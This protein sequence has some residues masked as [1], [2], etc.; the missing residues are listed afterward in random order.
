MKT[1]GVTGGS[2]FVGQHLCRLLVREGYEVIIFSR[3][4]SGVKPGGACRYAGWNP[5]AGTID[6]HALK[7]LDAVVN[8]AGA[9]I[10]E[11]RWTKKRKQELVSSR[12][13]S[14][15][16]LVGQLRLH[17][18]A[19]RV[20]LSASAAGYYGPDQRSMISFS[21]DASAYTDF[22]AGLC[23]EWEA[24]ANEATDFAR[25]VICRL[26]IVLGREAGAFPSFRNPVRFGI[27][28][29]LGSGRQV[30]SWIHVADLTALFL[31]LLQ[32]PEAG[33]FNAVSPRPVT[34]KELI[35]TIAGETGGLH[36]AMPVPAFILKTALGE[37][38]SEL[39]KSC[40]VSSDKIR[41]TGFRF[42]YPDIHTAV[43]N[44]I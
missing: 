20:F 29:V 44:L 41:S 6:T 37:M 24:A 33:I 22:L 27:A 18:P 12:T 25:V 32:R 23:V 4:K 34:Q 39:L 21:E 30:V 28:P 14:T 17:A 3:S 19:C 42:Q 7:A 9:G 35:K 26:G 43:R 1:I 11:K 38:A 15:R 10:A 5:D 8:L 13:G 16:F 2:G 40:T 31:Y 36:I